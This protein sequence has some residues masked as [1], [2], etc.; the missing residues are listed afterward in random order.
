M[1]KF[2]FH[3]LYDI[4]NFLI[5]GAKDFAEYANK[6]NGISCL[7]LAE[8]EIMADPQDIETSPKIPR[9]LKVHSFKNL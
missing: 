7:Y 9:T 2:E 4:K 6:I 1:F 3:Y 5:N 8:N